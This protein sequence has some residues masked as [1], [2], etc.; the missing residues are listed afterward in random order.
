MDQARALQKL[1]R[2]QISDPAEFSAALVA[3]AVA[4]G[5]EWIR[6]ETPQNAFRMEHNGRGIP[7]HQLITL[8]SSLL[9][10]GPDQD[11]A[12]VQELAHGLNA[13]LSLSPKQIR[14]TCSGLEEVVALVLDSRQLIVKRADPFEAYGQTVRTVIQV[15]GL[16]RSIKQRLVRGFGNR[17]EVDTLFRRCSFLQIPVLWQGREVDFPSGIPMAQTVAKI[18]NPPPLPFRWPDQVLEAEGPSPA[19]VGFCTDGPSELTV[20]SHGVSLTNSEEE[21]PEGI[22]AIVYSSDLRKDLSR[23]GVVN[24]AT[25][26]SVLD[27]L[28]ATSWDLLESVSHNANRNPY[29]LRRAVLRSIEKEA[30]KAKERWDADLSERLS[31]AARRLRS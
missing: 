12:P 17:P 23:A 18:G 25:Y 27:Q 30:K 10:T 6:L 21:L 1:R 9:V 19:W 8:F 13:L 2:Y 31:Q 29:E 3:S 7:H 14:V 11:L 5:A 24:D 15:D 20:V 28:K 4:S 16:W 22:Q 26:Q